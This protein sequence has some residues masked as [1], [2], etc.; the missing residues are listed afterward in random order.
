[1]TPSEENFRDSIATVN[2]SG[3]R[4]WLYPKKPKGAYYNKRKVAAF[5]LCAVLVGGAL[6]QIDGRQLFLFNVIDRKFHFFGQPFWAQDFHLLG[7]L[8]LIAVVFVVVFT[9]GYGRLFCGWVCP[10]TVFLEMIFRPIEYWIEGDRGAQRRLNKQPWNTPKIKKKLLK[11][12]I[13]FSFP[14]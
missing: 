1:M 9:V 2:S 10:Q 5:L 14:F 11:W 6:I 8:L 7:I 4:E 3:K 12:S 13:F